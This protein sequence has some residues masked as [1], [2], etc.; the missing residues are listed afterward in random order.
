MSEGCKLTHVFKRDGT[1]VPYSLQRISNAIYRA[2]VAVGGRDKDKAD[3][4]ALMVEGIICENYSN[5]HPPMVEQIQDIVEKVLIEEGHATVAKHFIVYRATQGEKRKAK[6]SK[7]T[8]H[9]GNIPYQ[10][11]MK[12]WSGHP[13]M[14]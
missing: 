1:Y 5:D 10:K 8:V 11:F 2:A 3:E 7:S 13:I 12:Y 14:I 9:T 4:L 6:L